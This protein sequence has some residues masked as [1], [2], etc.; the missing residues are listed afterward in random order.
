M[1]RKLFLLYCLFP[2]FLFGQGILSALE[3]MHSVAKGETWESIAAS[4]GVE[5]SD[6]QAANPDV[7]PGK[8]LRKGTLLIVPRKAA[9]SAS[10][11]V[12]EEPAK[13]VP[14]IRTSVRD[15]KVGV[16]LPFGE[17]NMVEFYR[18][19]LMAADSVRRAGVN[20]D[21]HAWE[22]GSTVASVEALADKIVGLDIL[23][24]PAGATQIPAVAEICKEQGTR[25]VLPFRTGQALYDY[26]LV[27][28]AASPRTLLYET[29]V[30]KLLNF[31]GDSNYV[32]VQTGKPDADGKAFCDVLLKKMEELSMPCRVLPL[33]GDDFA[34]E[35]AVNQYKGN[36]LIIDDSSLSSLDSLT[37]HLKAFRQKHP[38]YRLTLVGYADW[39]DANGS[40]PE[41]LTGIDTYVVS[42]YYYNASTDRTKR[43]ERLYAKNFRAY[44]SKN[45]PRYVALGYDLGCYFLSG[46]SAMG[47]TFE[48]MQENLPQEPYQSRFLFERADQHL[49]F[50]NRFVQFVH[51]SADGRVEL[52]R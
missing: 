49:S 34:Y 39:L 50:F 36:M 42:P 23:F 6:L 3:D 24:G 5:V 18:G 46:F 25:L 41:Q 1:K 33:A 38:Q 13:A 22:S 51:R 40:L 4:R 29:A 19:L 20:I 16:L 43:F 31:Y 44:I 27:Y 28:N 47:D 48:Q 32:I 9:A 2:T 12:A 15:L 7:S 30:R 17:A 14:V 8:K 21:I 35:S 52:V 45:N 11:S 26:P 10:E 37:S